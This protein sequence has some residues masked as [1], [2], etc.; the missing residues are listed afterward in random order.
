MEFLI[1]FEGNEKIW[2]RYNADLASST[3]FQHYCK[4]HAE[5]EPITMTLREWKVKSISYNNRG[6]VAVTPG[7]MCYVNLKSWGAEYFQSL[8]LP[9]GP[10]YVVQCNYLKWTTPQKKKIDV[11]CPL[12]NNVIF[13]WNAVSVR[14]YGMSFVLN[15][16]MVLVDAMFCRSHPKVLE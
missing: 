5:L 9:I 4:L 3:P 15:E 13:E 6:I 14:L 2:L 1:V 7:Q 16:A 11:Q 12:F 8:S 10:S